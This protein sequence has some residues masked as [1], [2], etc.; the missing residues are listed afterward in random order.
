VRETR[1][2]LRNG[3]IHRPRHRLREAGA[4][5]A[6]GA[7]APD[8]VARAAEAVESIL[9]AHRPAPLPAGAETR[10]AEILAAAEA[11]LPAR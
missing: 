10:I 7:S 1:A 2:F 8:E 9:A 11:A 6:P 3:E 4:T 5:G